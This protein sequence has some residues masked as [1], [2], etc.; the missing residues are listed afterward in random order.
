MY[1]FGQID[2][3]KLGD[4]A[5]KHPSLIRK[6]KF[7]DGREHQMLNVSIIDTPTDKFGNTMAIRVSCKPD[8]RVDGLNYYVANLRESDKDKS[9]N[10]QPAQAPPQPQPQQDYYEQNDGDN[11]LPF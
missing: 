3:T 7:K 1:S 4:I 11:D 6:V 2:L 5:K 8:D 10:H 9:E